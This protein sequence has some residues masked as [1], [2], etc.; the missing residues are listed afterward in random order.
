MIRWSK[1]IVSGT[2]NVSCQETEKVQK[3]EMSLCETTTTTLMWILF[4]CTLLYNYTIYLDKKNSK[5][6]GGWFLILQLDTTFNLRLWVIYA[7]S[8]NF[9]H[10]RGLCHCVFYNYWL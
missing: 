6:V 8:H 10:L 5:C 2:R 9:N 4:V 3:S 1:W 7:S